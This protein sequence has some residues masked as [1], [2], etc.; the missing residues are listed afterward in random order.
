MT[1][2][3]TL[4]LVLSSIGLLSCVCHAGLIYTLP[5]HGF[6]PRGLN[7]KGSSELSRLVY[8]DVQATG[9]YYQNDGVRESLHQLSFS[10]RKDFETFW[11]AILSVKS[12]G[13]PL[14]LRQGKSFYRKQ[15]LESCGVQILF[16]MLDTPGLSKPGIDPNALKV[17]REATEHL[18]EYV[19]LKEG[20]FVPYTDAL[21]APRP[22]AIDRPDP[23]YRVRTDIILVV[24]GDVVDLNRIPIP[25]DT[26][27]IDERFPKRS[28]D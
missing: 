19:L 8:P 7:P 18:P 17:L 21:P 4:F 28:E 22:L 10:K 20:A 24:D 25:K 6:W 11:P 2:K 16:P 5:F 1:K 27:V 9:C 26:P 23:L 3:A 14:I 15:S 13:A 12:P